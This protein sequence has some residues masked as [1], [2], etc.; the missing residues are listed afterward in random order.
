MVVMWCLC[1]KEY[2]VLCLR[3]IW[4]L[5]LI[6][7]GV[8]LG[9]ILGVYVGYYLVVYYRGICGGYIE[10]IFGVYVGGVCGGHDW[11]IRGGYVEG[12]FVGYI[13]EI[14]VFEYAAVIMKLSWRN[15]PTF[16]FHSY[17]INIIIIKMI[18]TA[19]EVIHHH[20]MHSLWLKFATTFQNSEQQTTSNPT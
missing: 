2:L 16:S 3:N 17:I 18:M 11:G 5:L 8:C 9:E 14:F 15:S 1:L 19:I 12:I 7:F 20:M 4:R 6:L 13:G 10:G